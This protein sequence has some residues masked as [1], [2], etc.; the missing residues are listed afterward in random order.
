M[1]FVFIFLACYLAA[2][3]LARIIIG[4]KIKRTAQHLKATMPD[5]DLSLYY[6]QMRAPILRGTIQMTLFTGTLLGLLASGMS[7]VL[8]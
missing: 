2:F 6:N 4:G 8:M 1:V 7:W 3:G 5:A